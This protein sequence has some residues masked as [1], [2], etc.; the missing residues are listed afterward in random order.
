MNRKIKETDK[1]VRRHKWRWRLLAAFLM[2]IVAIWS[3]PRLIGVGPAK[4]ALLQ[5]VGEKTGWL[6]DC[7]S[8]SLSWLGPCELGRVQ[9]REPEGGNEISASFISWS[10]GLIDLL[11]EARKM[12]NTQQRHVPPGLLVLRGG[13]IKAFKIEGRQWQDFELEGEIYID[14][15][16]QQR[17]TA[18][19]KYRLDWQQAMGMLEIYAP[20]T[21]RDVNLEGICQGEF[22]LKSPVDGKLEDIEGVLSLNWDRGEVYEIKLGQAQI[23]PEISGGIVHL[24]ESIVAAEDGQ[25][26]LAG[27]LD[28]RQQ[29]PQ[30]RITKKQQILDKLPIKSELVQ[31]FM[32]DASPLLAESAEVEGTVSL[33]VED[34][35]V[36]LDKNS[37]NEMYGQGNLNLSGMKVHPQGLL[38]DLL[39]LLSSRVEDK[40]CLDIGAINFAV[41][42][43]KIHYDDFIVALKDHTQMRFYGSVGFDKTMD[44]AVSMP[45]NALLLERL[46]VKMSQIDPRYLGETRVDIPILGTVDKPVLGLGKVNVDEL[47]KNILRKNIETQAGKALED[48]LGKIDNSGQKPET[49]IETNNQDEEKNEQAPQQEK[50]NKR[51]AEEQMTNILIDVLGNVLEKQKK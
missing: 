41:R 33:I 10:G 44:M 50:K 51:T 8:I 37:Q 12:K 3:V 11:A 17:A 20:E 29:P 38:K 9:L 34:V 14:G 16:A 25:I 22:E 28:L 15:T 36:P 1:I 19:G 43:G 30:L 42:D 49:P 24:P 48:L 27:Q 18:N 6:I 26:I 45:L 39:N 35:Y 47:L 2:L 13:V 32:K 46:G 31:R 21:A 23:K 4:S 40:V 7:Q 5:L